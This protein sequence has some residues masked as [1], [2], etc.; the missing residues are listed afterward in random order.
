MAQTENPRKAIREARAARLK[1]I[2]GPPKTV[3]VYPA[4]DTF[5]AILRHASG[6]RFPSNGPADWPVDGFTTRRLAEGSISTESGGGGAFAEPD[7]TKNA[8]E[9]AAANKPKSKKSEP[10]K[11]APRQSQPPAA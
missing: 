6:T 10:P 9:Q 7:P 4:N 8:R 11:A 5:R 2:E 1:V 3:K